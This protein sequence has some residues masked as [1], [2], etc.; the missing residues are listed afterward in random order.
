MSKI[1][2]SII[3]VFVLAILASCA[4]G[5]SQTSSAR[6]AYGDPAPFKAHVKKNNKKKKDAQKAAKKQKA[7]RSGRPY[8]RLP[9]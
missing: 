4:Q 9:M 7:V 3:V 5:S 2:Q 6:A 1:F 8:Q